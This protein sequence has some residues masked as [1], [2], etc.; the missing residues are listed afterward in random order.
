MEPV[1]AEHPRRLGCEAGAE[2]VGV[3]AAGDMFDMAVARL[4]RQLKAVREA[5]GDRAA[6]VA[7]T[8]NYNTAESIELSEDAPIISRS[9]VCATRR[10]A[11]R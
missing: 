3:V 5:V 10:I 6:V 8:C 4:A 1:G 2:Q 7:G 9:V 11:S